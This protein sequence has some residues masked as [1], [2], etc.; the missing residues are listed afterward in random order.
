MKINKANWL[1]ALVIVFLTMIV[2][3]CVVRFTPVKSVDLMLRYQEKE[4]VL[5]TSSLI[6]VKGLLL[7]GAF[8]MLIFAWFLKIILSHTN[9]TLRNLIRCSELVLVEDWK[10]A[11]TYQSTIQNTID[12]SLH[13]YKKLL[14]CRISC[15]TL[16]A[17]ISNLKSLAE[18]Q[19][20]SLFAHKKLAESFFALEDYNQSLIYGKY[21]LKK[22]QKDEDILKIHLLSLSK[23]N[24]WHEYFTQLEHIG[25]NQV[26]KLL[27]PEKLSEIYLEFAKHEKK[28]LRYESAIE[29]AK[30]SLAFNNHNIES[31]KFLYTTYSYQG[32]N[33][34]SCK[35]LEEQFEISP[36][37]DVCIALKQ[38]SPLDSKDLY[39]LLAKLANPAEN[40]EVFLAICAYLELQAEA[41]EL[42]ES[43]NV[44]KK[45]YRT[46]VY[47][48]NMTP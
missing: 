42:I 6:I 35:V 39:T 14:K 48:N 25:T 15:A 37:L 3:Y 28:S 44:Y 30:K 43:T 29:A 27:S 22:S 36:S 46:L 7:I 45:R 34:E 23:L 19:E 12:V 24:L 16:N 26:A 31:F 4:Y 20:F 33:Q 18:I 2:F 8:V 21:V 13:N 11:D 38:L 17:T 5:R 10:T 32:L 41:K 47:E 40:M 1:Y 9:K